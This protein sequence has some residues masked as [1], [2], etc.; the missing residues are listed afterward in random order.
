[1][2]HVYKGR[3]PGYSEHDLALGFA[4]TFDYGNQFWTLGQHR[5]KSRQDFVDRLKELLLIGIPGLNFVKDSL[6]TR[7]I[8]FSAGKSPDNAPAPLSLRRN[9][10][11]D[12]DCEHLGLTGGKLV[13]TPSD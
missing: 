6:Q 3:V 2:D 10:Q 7:V 4:E 12:K 1:M 13:A 9:S 5:L 11:P 8:A